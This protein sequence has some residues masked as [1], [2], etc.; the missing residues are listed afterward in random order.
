[1][2]NVAIRE[3]ARENK[4]KHWQIADY[5][6]VSEQTFMR[7]LRKKLPADKEKQVFDAIDAISSRQEAAQ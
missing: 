6:G 2:E 3:K 1:M 7:W 4:V 5:I